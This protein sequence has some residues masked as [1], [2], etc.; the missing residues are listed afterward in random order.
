MG[1][2]RAFLENEFLKHGRNAIMKINCVSCGHSIFLDDAYD[3]F[4]GLVKCYVCSGLL[5]I[6]TA[7][8]KI[9][10]IGLA[11]ME[12]SPQTVVKHSP[13]ASKEKQA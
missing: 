2:P 6:K 13:A 10:A 5:H 11:S 8:G 1:A 3:D 12:R 4:D 9:K 7:E